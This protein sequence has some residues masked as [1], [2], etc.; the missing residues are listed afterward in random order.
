MLLIA[1]GAD[2]NARLPVEYITNSTTTTS[3]SSETNDNSVSSDGP[4]P[5][6]SSSSSSMQLTETSSLHAA[7]QEGSTECVV[8]LLLNGAEAHG[9]LISQSSSGSDSSGST[10]IIVGIEEGPKVRD[11]E[12]DDLQAVDTSN[13]EPT[14]A[15]DGVID[16]ETP[17]NLEVRLLFPSQIALLSGHTKLSAYIRTKAETK[18]LQTQKPQA[19]TLVDSVVT[20]VVGNVTTTTSSSV[21]GENIEL[22]LPTVP[23][24][25]AKE[26]ESIAVEVDFTNFY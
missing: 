20:G 5:S 25:T 19:S 26:A 15:T 21:V 23:T 12:V 10:K 17:P 2:V 16:S 8:A 1:H 13:P 3:S 22:L 18:K 9:L 24:R 11:D 7:A 6:S 14:A 4:P